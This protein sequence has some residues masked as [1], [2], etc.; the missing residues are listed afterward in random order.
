MLNVGHASIPE[1][2]IF[3]ASYEKR[4]TLWNNRNTFTEQQRKWY[5]DNFE[6]QDA[7]DVVK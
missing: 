1:V 3:E 4:F 2:E 6:D 7:E 5:L